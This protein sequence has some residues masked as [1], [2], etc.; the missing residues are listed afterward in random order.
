MKRRGVGIS[1][2]DTYVFV[3]ASN[4]RSTCLKTLGVRIDFEKLYKYF[5][6]KYSKFK[7]AYYFEGIADNDETKA[8]VFG[9]LESVGYQ[10]KTLS[11]KAYMN[12]AVYKDVRCRKC[13][14]VQK[15]QILK[16]SISLKSNVDVYLATELLSVAYLSEAPIHLVVVSCDGDYAE[17][18]KNVILKND[19]VVISV[20]A[21]PSVRDMRKNTLSVR[22]KRI[23]AELQDKRNR[24]HLCNIETLDCFT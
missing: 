24:Y 15:T 12:P 5:E 11:R 21:T 10:V 22:L 2:I 14:N 13:G 9:R 7:G 4:I 1:E 16:K 18:I 6:R 20:L 17:M 3:D 19:N 23:Y 8:K